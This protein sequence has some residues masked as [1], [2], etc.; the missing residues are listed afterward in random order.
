MQRPGLQVR[1]QVINFHRLTN[2]SSIPK[3]SSGGAENGRW[4]L[5]TG[6]GAQKRVVGGKKM[7]EKKKTG[8]GGGLT[9]EYGVETI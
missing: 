8:R 6:S 7:K 5:K 9:V 3:S 2:S 4:S 1:S